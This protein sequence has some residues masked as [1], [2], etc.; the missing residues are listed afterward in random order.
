VLKWI[1]KSKKEISFCESSHLDV[2]NG[3][4]NIWF[5]ATRNGNKWNELEWDYFY[6]T[7]VLLT[8]L[9]LPMVFVKQ[10]VLFLFTA[11]IRMY[12]WVISPWLGPSKCRYT[13]SCS[14]YCMQALHKHGLVKGF[15]LSIKRIARCAPWGSHGFDPVP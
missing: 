5:L 3:I 10:I 1:R 13:P 6:P 8:L 4:I 11:L 2:W 12:Q 15:W 9:C 7:L 14:E